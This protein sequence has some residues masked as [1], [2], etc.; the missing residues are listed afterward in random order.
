MEI[1]AVAEIKPPS[2]YFD[3]VSTVQ[4]YMEA[5]S[6][7]IIEAK[8]EQA[9]F[10]GNTWFRGIGQ[11]YKIPLAPGIYR[12]KFTARAKAFG[13]G[14]LEG[15]RQHLERSMLR[16]FRTAGA[17]FFNA[18]DIADV[19]LSAQHFEMPT[20]LLDWTT[21][22]LVALFFAVKDV[23]KHGREGEVFAVEPKAILPPPD[24][25]K[26]ADEI[27]RDAEIMRHPYVAYAIGQSFWHKGK[28]RPPVTIPVVPDNRL[29]RI[30]Q[31]SSC[32]TLHMHKAPDVAVPDGKLAKFEILFE[33]SA[34]AKI[35]DDLLRLKIN[36]FT[37]YNDLDHLSKDIKRVWGVE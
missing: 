16:E 2:K 1:V 34:K 8:I 17:T 5:V 22:P 4:G 32:F 10:L 18:S 33:D 15:A 30:G 9:T 12:D 21:N 29:G 26:K 31:Q 28:Y 36:Q 19:Y 37:I 3:K 11:V 13:W 25:K 35:L 23:D 20:R 7:W 27:L 6:R 14:D 24:P